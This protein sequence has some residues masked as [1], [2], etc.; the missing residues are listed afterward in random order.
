MLTTKI[1]FAHEAIYF[2]F[3]LKKGNKIIQRFL[4]NYS[5][6]LTWSQR[7]I[8]WKIGNNFSDRVTI[9]KVLMPPYFEDKNSTIFFE[10][11]LTYPRVSTKILIQW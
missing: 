3:I 6:D 10:R 7:W 11:S 9:D 4:K 5:R 1:A 2:F 8:L